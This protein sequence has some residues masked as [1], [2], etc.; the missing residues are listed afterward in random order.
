MNVSTLRYLVNS[1]THKFTES[2]GELTKDPE[3]YDL[4]LQHGFGDS[5]K[6]YKLTPVGK[7]DHANKTTTFVITEIEGP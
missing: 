2:G 7:V 6:T 4:V 5:V 1:L 3:E